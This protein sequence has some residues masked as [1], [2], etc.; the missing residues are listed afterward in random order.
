MIT[1]QEFK[2]ELIP[3]TINKPERRE[4]YYKKYMDKGITIEDAYEQYRKTF[5]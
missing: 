1:F 4:D 3:V 2:D 5:K